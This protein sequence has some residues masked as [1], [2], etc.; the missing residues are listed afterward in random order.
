MVGIILLLSFI[1]PLMFGV[2][3]AVSMGLPALLGY[4]FKAIPLSYL[5]Q[6]AYTSVDAFTLIAIPMFILAGNLMMHGG[7]TEGIVNF[8]KELVGKAT[9]GLAAVTIVA[10]TFFGA[11]SGSGPATTAAVG[12]ILIPALIKSNYDKPFAGSIA[13]CSGGIGA[14]IPPSILMIMYAITAEQSPTT[15]FIAGIIPGI[16]LGIFLYGAVFIVSKKRNYQSQAN[17]MNV[18]RVLRS[19]YE[20]KWGLLSPLIIFG[21]IYTGITTVTEASVILVVYAF[22]IGVFVTKKLN[23]SN[24]FDSLYGMLKT[25]GAIFFILTTGMALGRI[26][27]IY[28]LPQILSESLSVFGNFSFV[29]ILIIGAILIFVGMWMES[30]TA[31]IILTP[32]FLPLMM[33]A[34]L[35]PIQF[36]VMFVIACEVGFETPPMGANLFVASE[37]S[38]ASIESI[39]KEAII[40]AG[41]EIIVMFLV[42][43][44]PELSLFLPRVMGML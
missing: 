31:I 19:M 44:I 5:V 32:L 7:L 9:G 43:F 16:L 30:N 38:G 10:C 33:S 34:G 1:V 22:I 11:I 21:F 17:K 14:V 15:L 4:V 36:G 12:S 18:K 8:S 28:Q 41:A 29:M 26:I 35:H 23:F 3:L 27:A 20:A 40:F 25:V 42:A 24:I 37:L 13:A 2:P 39:S 6:G